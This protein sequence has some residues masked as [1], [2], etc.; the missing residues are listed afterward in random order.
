MLL[1]EEGDEEE[2][3]HVKKRQKLQRVESNAS[4][5]SQS[6]AAP[7]SAVDMERVDSNDGSFVDEGSFGDE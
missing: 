6:T 5:A 7:L 2:N 3:V 1:G 4:F